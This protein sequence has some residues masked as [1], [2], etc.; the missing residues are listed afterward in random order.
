MTRI[1]YMD[2]IGDLIR[3]NMQY[4]DTIE[5]ILDKYGASED[6]SDPDEG[7][8]V[9][10]SDDDIRRAYDA[11]IDRLRENENPETQYNILIKQ[12]RVTEYEQGW[13]DGYEAAQWR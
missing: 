5:S 11:I 13:I 12:S 6:D 3:D 9:T 10:M 1:E 7:Y 4:I 8:F 2:A